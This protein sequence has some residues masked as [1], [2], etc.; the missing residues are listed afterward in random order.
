VT[1][2]I[3]SRYGIFRL[4]WNATNWNELVPQIFTL[5]WP[6]QPQRS[7]IKFGEGQYN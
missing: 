1:L 2:N 4:T 5:H 6:G 7:V 3:N